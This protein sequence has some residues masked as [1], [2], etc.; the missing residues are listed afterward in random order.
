MFRLTPPPEAFAP[1]THYSKE[2]R[3][4]AGRVARYVMKN[5]SRGTTNMPAPKEI[6]RLTIKSDDTLLASWA[7]LENKGIDMRVYYPV[8]APYGTT[9]IVAFPL[10]ADSPAPAEEAA[11]S[12]PEPQNAS[13]PQK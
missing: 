3:F 4:R 13:L 9:R 5:F 7:L 6:G 12:R 2:D 1:Y 8:D 10:E 11:N